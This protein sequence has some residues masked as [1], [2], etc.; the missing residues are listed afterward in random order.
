M[1]KRN[2]L[3]FIITIIFI[4]GLEVFLRQYY[5]MCSAVLYNEDSSFEY[6]AKPNQDVRRFRNHIVYNSES[7][8]SEAVDGSSYKILGFG[9]SIINGGVMV[10]QDSIATSILSTGLSKLYNKKVQFLNISQGSWGPDNCYAYLNRYGNFGA[11]YIFLFVS[12]HDAYDNMDFQK[13]V[14]NLENYPNEQYSFGIYELLERYLIP[15]LKDFFKPGKS[16]VNLLINKKKKN[17]VFN[18]GFNSF[19]SYSKTHSIPLIIY[20]HADKEEI[21]NGVYNIQGQEIIKFARCNNLDIIM[22]MKSNLNSNCFLDNIHL[23]SMGQRKLGLIVFNY[24]STSQ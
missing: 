5:G 2:K 11:K 20:L 24:F 4:T 10:D 14:G 17:S 21:K 7:M 22:D 8:R 23:N 15:R 12:S 1:I 19:L 13:V 6:I 9:D 18:T 16:D 3:I